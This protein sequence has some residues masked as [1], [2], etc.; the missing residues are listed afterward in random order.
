MSSAS[1]PVRKLGARIVDG[2]SPQGIYTLE[3]PLDGASTL[4]GTIERLRRRS[5]VILSVEAPSR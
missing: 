4:A 3:V 2:P 1:S 5:D